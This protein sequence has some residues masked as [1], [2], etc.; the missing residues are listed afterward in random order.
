LIGKFLLGLL[1][2]QGVGG[3][4]G[5][6]GK[7]GVGGGSGGGGGKTQIFT[8]S[9]PYATGGG[10]LVTQSG[11]DWVAA[12]GTSAFF[13]NAN[14]IY[15]NSYPAI[16]SWGGAGGTATTNQGTKITF[17]VVAGSETGPAVRVASGNAYFADCYSGGCKIVKIVGGTQTGLTSFGAALSTGAVVELDATGTSSTVLTLYVNGTS[18]ATYTDTSSPLT[19]GTWGI[20]SVYGG[21]SPGNTGVTNATGYNL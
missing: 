7:A 3:H 13:L 6:G 10:D 14:A 20:T 5:F 17:S 19:T 9:F 15:N 18:Y 11:G 8:N 2:F 1:L 21:S 16:V 4:G 12:Y